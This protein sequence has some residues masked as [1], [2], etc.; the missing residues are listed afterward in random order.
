MSASASTGPGCAVRAPRTGATVAGFLVRR[1]AGLVVVLL[2][3]S[4][5]TF[6]LAQ[7]APGD[8]ARAVAVDR[9]GDAATA[10]D[11]EAVRA[12]LGLDGP[13]AEQYLRFL[14]NALTG[15]L[16]QSY[17]T[18]QPVTSELAGRVPVTLGLAS[19]GGGLGVAL[20]L[21]LG[22]ASVRARGRFV[23]GV[24]RTV[25]LTASAVPPFWLG[26]LLVLYLALTLGLVPT[27]G[28]AGPST[29][30][31]PTVV[32]ALPLAGVLSRVVAV[33]VADALAA[34]HIQA[35]V[36][37]GASPRR[38]LLREALPNAAGPVLTV[39]GFTVAG[40]LV[41]TVIVEQIFGWPG[42]GDYFA[43]AVAARDLPALQGGVAYFGF[44]IVAANAAAD[45]LHGLVDPRVRS[46]R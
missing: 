29:W 38:I 30:L 41:G 22:L 15:D 19:L 40:L 14:G 21:A 34:P 46:V 44:A 45:A 3:L 13:V 6:A 25:G 17:R 35:A 23:R 1:A 24:L 10:A 20:G 8:P 33:T 11:I 16:G 18:G 37:R 2:A 43:Q 32:L 26:Y 9:I 36:A 42:V 28:M 4:V 7:L 12:E 31:L 5:V 39:A 27:G